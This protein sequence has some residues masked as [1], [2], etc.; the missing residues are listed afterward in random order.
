MA[1]LWGSTQK[2]ALNGTF[3]KLPAGFAGTI[4]SDGSSFGAVVIQG[5]VEYPVG[6]VDTKV[7]GPG[8]Y[9]H[10]EGKVI[11]QVASGAGKESILYV[12]TDGK[13]DVIPAQ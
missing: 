1:F 10:S 11:H 9:F 7:L 8:S 3:I 13:Y 12:R 5:Q 4:N 6:Q 2:G